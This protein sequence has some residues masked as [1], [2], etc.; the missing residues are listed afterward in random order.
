MDLTETSFENFCL[1]IMNLRVPLKAEKLLTRL[2]NIEIINFS[3]S[4]N[5]M[6]IVNHLKPS[7]YYMYHLLQHISAFC[8]QNVSVCSV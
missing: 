4:F 3:N 1:R 6:Q 5:N 8:P 7:G 2:E